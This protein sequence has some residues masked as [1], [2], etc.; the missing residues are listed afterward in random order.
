MYFEE[1]MID[2]VMCYRTNP[3]AEF[4]PYSLE[5]LSHRYKEAQDDARRLRRELNEAIF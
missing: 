2:G 3:Q 1:K 5:E 4:E